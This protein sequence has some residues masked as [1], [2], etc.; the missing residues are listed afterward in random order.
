MKIGFLGAGNMAS[1]IIRGMVA[2][3]IPASAIGCFDVDQQKTFA[4]KEELGVAVC[5]TA[6]QLCEEAQ[7][8]VLAIKPQVFASALPPLR[9]LMQVQKPLVISIAA[10]KTL[11]SITDL[12]GD[13]PMVRV[14]PN[15][16][17]RVGEAVT[18][19]CSNALVTQS[20][21]ETV[22]D[23]FESVG[24]V[25]PLAE[26]QFGIFSVL[27]GC[28]P[29]YTLLYMDAL[30]TAGVRGGIPKETALQIVTQAVLGTAKLL[31]EAGEHPRELIDS[32]CSPAGTTIEGVCALQSAGFEKAVQEA[33]KASLER[34]KKLQNA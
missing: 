22:Y 12:I 27:A 34:D 26:E 13:V 30:A 25:V 16:A 7:T 10:G 31:Q 5:Y 24:T 14:M 20:H 19:Y 8:V 21:V 18:A 33:A 6:E 17:A 32:V 1:A 9:T 28:S 4:L 29:A 15:I 11:Q 2:N 3:G 23:I